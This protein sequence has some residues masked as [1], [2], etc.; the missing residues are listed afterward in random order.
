MPR[1]DPKKPSRFPSLPNP[2]RIQNSNRSSPIPI[3]SPNSS[4]AIPSRRA[5]RSRSPIGRRANQDCW[6]PSRHG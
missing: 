1:M 4:R 6:K 2:N 5:I 3:P